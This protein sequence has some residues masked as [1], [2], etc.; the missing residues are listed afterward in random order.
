MPRA[1]TVYPA[2]MT[3]V[4]SNPYILEV[5]KIAC[6]TYFSFQFTICFSKNMT[7]SNIIFP[8]NHQLEY[9]KMIPLGHISGTHGLCH[10]KL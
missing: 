1:I 9:E 2:G 10:I 4:S 5:K 3:K 7:P 6:Q 8:R